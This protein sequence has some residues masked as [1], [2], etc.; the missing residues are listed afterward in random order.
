LLFTFIVFVF[1]LQYFFGYQILFP[2][3]A[4]WVGLLGT[5]ILALIISV[6]PKFFNKDMLRAIAHLPV[7]MFAMMKALFK[8]KSN[9]K[10]FLH[11][12]KVHTGD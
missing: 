2:S 5:Y 7:L 1:L 8:M 12:P 6:P 3:F 4:S 11:T 10:E 9:R